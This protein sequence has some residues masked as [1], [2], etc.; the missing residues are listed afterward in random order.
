[1]SN[2]NPTPTAPRLQAF[3]VINSSKK[4]VPLLSLSC[5]DYLSTGP[6]VVLRFLSGIGFAMMMIS[7]LKCTY[8]NVIIAWVILYMFESFRKEVPW[9]KCDNDW[10][11]GLCRW[12]RTEIKSWKSPKHIFVDYKFVAS[13]TIGFPDLADL[14]A[15]KIKKKPMI[16]SARCTSRRSRC[17]KMR[18]VCLFFSQNNKIVW[19]S[20]MADTF[21]EKFTRCAKGCGFFS[22]CRFGC[23]LVG[24]ANYDHMVRINFPCRCFVP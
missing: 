14:W 4:T 1:M 10:N 7:F 15:V 13:H 20:N 12:V 18:K 23:W 3:Q 24:Q 19:L 9:K 17:E 5:P 8:Y 2:S 16:L 11:T 22:W 21:L 6:N